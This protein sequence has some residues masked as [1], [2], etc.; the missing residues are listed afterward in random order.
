MEWN[1]DGI[2]VRRI[3]WCQWGAKRRVKRAQTQ[4]R[5]PP[6]TPAEIFA[7]LILQQQ[8]QL[9]KCLKTKIN[10]CEWNLFNFYSF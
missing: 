10:I 3:R 4:E 2:N 5:G 6:S 9:S 1:D 8:K 7:I